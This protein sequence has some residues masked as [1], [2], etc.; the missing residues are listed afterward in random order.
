MTFY[1]EKFLEDFPAYEHLVDSLNLRHTEMC[2]ARRS[3]V[4]EWTNGM[5]PSVDLSFA[6]IHRG[7]SQGGT[8]LVS[9]GEHGRYKPSITFRFDETISIGLWLHEIGHVCCGSERP[10]ADQASRVERHA[11]VFLGSSYGRTTD[12]LAH[13]EIAAWAAALILT[14]PLGVDHRIVLCELLLSAAVSHRNDLGIFLSSIERCE[15]VTG[16]ITKFMTERE[17]IHPPT[18]EHDLFTWV[19]DGAFDLIELIMPWGPDAQESKIGSKGKTRR[20]LKA[21]I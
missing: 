14:K 12:V 3:D 15:S 5:Q 13:M 8:T 2:H 10:Q 20:R 21:A 6:P 19:C 11:W 1:A 16:G 7:E 17:A 4:C 18:N 9:F